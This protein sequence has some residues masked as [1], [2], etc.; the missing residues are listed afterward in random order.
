LALLLGAA[1]GAGGL[2][3]GLHW[4]RGGGAAAAPE[5]AEQ[6]R[7][8]TEESAALKRENDSLRSL[9]QGGGEF[10]VPQEL[11][12]RI[13]QDFDL[14]FLSSPVVHRIAR[15]ELRDRIGAAVESRFGPAG[16]DDRQE[17]YRLIGWLDEDHPLLAELTAVLAVG[18]RG[19]FDDVSGAGWVTDQ[20]S[21]EN[22]PDQATLMRLLTRIL[23][24]QHFPPPPAY[25][26]DDADR[27]RL[28][29]HQGTAA[30]SE[31]RHYAANARAIGFVPLKQDEE[32]ARTF[33]TLAPFVQSLSLFPATVGK[34]FADALY[35]Q[36]NDKLHA[37]F[38]NPPQTTRA[39][40]QPATPPAAPPVLTMPAL[41]G[42]P[43]TPDE[44]FL[45]ESAGQ[46]GLR[47]W[48]E[49]AGEEEG[50]AEI[51][52]HWTND[53][54]LLVPDG[55]TDSA[56]VWDI[57][58][59]SAAAVDRLLPLAL[60]RT[61]A[62]AGAAGPAGLAAPVVSPTGRHLQLSRPA[63]ARLRFLN[64]ATAATAARW[65]EARVSS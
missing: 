52:G 13:E 8:A 49:A 57:E 6:L 26:G 64:A 38:R 5:L 59:D 42:A 16:I 9:A 32:A 56:L 46:L 22:I 17:A 11:V 53:R 31:A 1:I 36:G 28:A 27:A 21:L 35:L 45:S 55:E 61:A 43:G 63:P 40:L 2:L 19:W 54:Y 60:A 24:H 18:V 39:I 4:R 33:A 10:A 41:A 14:R 15:E 51:A 47:L 7:L 12:D 25:P 58:L 29:L 50:A 20:F 30:G 62:L 65:R 48:L 23:F 37:A 44:P 3:Q 34:G